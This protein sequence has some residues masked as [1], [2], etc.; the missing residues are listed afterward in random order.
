MSQKITQCV[1]LRPDG[2]ASKHLLGETRLIA[3]NELMQCSESPG[4]SHK[5]LFLSRL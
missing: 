4:N 2:E 3:V 5:D 1:A